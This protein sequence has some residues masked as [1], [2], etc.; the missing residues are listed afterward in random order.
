M[1]PSDAREHRKGKRRSGGVKIIINKKKACTLYAAVYTLCA[2][3]SYN[4]LIRRVYTTARKHCQKQKKKPT[5]YELPADEQQRTDDDDDETTSPTTSAKP[6]MTRAR[7]YVRAIFTRRRRRRHRTR[8][9]D[10]RRATAAGRAHVRRVRRT[11]SAVFRRSRRGVYT[12]R[13]TRAIYKYKWARATRDRII[14]LQRYII[15][16]VTYTRARLRGPD[17]CSS[18]VAIA[19]APLLRFPIS[20]PPPVPE[21]PY[22]R[23]GAIK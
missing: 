21:V 23:C 4:I 19:R 9:R 3:V 8:R 1:S 7:A 15:V 12:K 18:Y 13:G 5:V 14:L 16:I 11:R 2:L 6:L 20:A 22:T 17:A 10:S